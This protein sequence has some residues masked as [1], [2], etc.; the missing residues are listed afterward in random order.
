ME[1]GV[2]DAFEYNNPTSDRRFG[3]A[4]VAKVYMLSSY[5]QASEA[6]EIN[7]NKTKWDALPPEHK[8][9]IE[10]SVEAANSRNFWTAYYQ[11]PID[12][13]ELIHKDGVKVYRT[14]ESILKA[15]LDAWDKVVK[16]YSAEVP[17]FKQISDHQRAWAK[18]SAYYNLLN[19]A[20]LKLAY[21][22]YYGKELPLGF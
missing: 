11:Y 21:D 12:L 15:Q 13:Q 10:H 1:K 14:P 22:H 18:N 7:I 3:A 16:Q 6:L 19:Q 2:I 8:A 20:D 5:H 17:E 9:I 4:D